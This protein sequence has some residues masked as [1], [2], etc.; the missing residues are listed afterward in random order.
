MSKQVASK[1]PRPGTSW[2][3][4]LLKK[5]RLALGLDRCVGLY[6]GAAP[7]SKD[8]LLYFGSLGMTVLEVYGMSECTGPQTINRPSAH[9]TGTAGPSI[10]GTE[11]KIADPDKDG[12]G[13]ICYRGRHIF[14]GYMKNDK[15][16]SET[17]DDEGWLHSGDIG[18]VDKDGFLQ[19]TGRIKELIITAG[20]E[21]IPPVLIEDEIIKEIG[22]IISNVMA[23]GDRRKFLTAVVTLKA[24]PKKDAK[25][26]EYPFTDNLAP[27]ALKEL[28]NIGSSAT[29][30]AEAIKDEKVK[31]Y[32]EDGIKRANKRATSNA[33]TIQKFE[34]LPE[35]FSIEGNELTPTM[36]LKR[37]IVTEKYAPV[38]EKMYDV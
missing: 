25:P 14:M 20:G 12:N 3:V 32:I 6:T 38:I 37:R 18:R 33:Q 16:T 4:G 27:N 30:I 21:N 24:E 2:T 31:K 22:P 35:D 10:P 17:I 26:G 1:E 7:I 19:I 13:E 9:K 36:K 5:V 15:A 11:M 29:T 23:I 8:T 28:Q 34:I